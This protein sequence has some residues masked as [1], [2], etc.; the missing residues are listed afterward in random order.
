[1]ARITFTADLRALKA[2]AV[3]ITADATRY[4]LHGVNIEHTSA[5]LTCVATDGARMIVAQHDWR[6]ATGA[7]PVFEPVIIPADLF[8]RVKLPARPIT[9][10][11]TVTLDYRDNDRTPHVTLAY[12]GATVTSGAIDGSYPNWRAVLPRE[13]ASGEAAHYDVSHLESFRDAVKAL[14]GKTDK[15]PFIAQNGP[16]NPALV[17]LRTKEDGPVRA[18]GVVMPVRDKRAAP[19]RAAPL[20]ATPGWAHAQ[21]TPTA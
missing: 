8:K 20:R 13:E 21:R 1:M 2:C 7:P 9:T 15:L 17:D 4:Y 6:D 3:V 5:G 10:D 19:L 11:V 12:D 16:G 14:H 18:F